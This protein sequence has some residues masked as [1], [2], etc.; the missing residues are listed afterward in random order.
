MCF[1]I[2]GRFSATITGPTDPRRYVHE[3]AHGFPAP[4]SAG[5]VSG[6]LLGRRLQP[7]IP[8]GCGAVPGLHL[9]GGEGRLHE[10]LTRLLPAKLCLPVLKLSASRLIRGHVTTWQPSLRQP[11]C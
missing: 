4:V 8:G 5:P 9:P 3:P 7:E 11:A 6:Q 10:L 1:S 2:A